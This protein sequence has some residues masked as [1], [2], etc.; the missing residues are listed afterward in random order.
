MKNVLSL[1]SRLPPTLTPHVPPPPP[2]PLI[3]P[4]GLLMSPLAPATAPLGS[5]R[6]ELPAH[7]LRHPRGRPG[8]SYPSGPSGDSPPWGG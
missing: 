3:Y 2:P 6:D 1:I 4:Y 5:P 7:A 8:L